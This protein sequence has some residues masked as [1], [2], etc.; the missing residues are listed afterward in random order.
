[1]NGITEDGEL[2][3]DCWVPAEGPLRPGDVCAAVPFA[4]LV[5]TPSAL[6]YQHD[7]I[8]EG[9]AVP[10]RLAYGLVVF[11]FEGYAVLAAVTPAEVFEDPDDFDRLA[12]AAR[13]SSVMLGL[14][15]LAAGDGWWHAAV[16]LLFMVET[17]P[18]AA[19]QPA[20]VTSMA[21]VARDC[22]RARLARTFAW[23]E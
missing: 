23:D 1:M 21:D 16:A 4:S 8:P 17:L 18:V 2:C 20:R 14:P 7:E 22:V 9:Y 15:R 12:D 13:T 3:E 10:V 6:V 19:V 5:A 11:V